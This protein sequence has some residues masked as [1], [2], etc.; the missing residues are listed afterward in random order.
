MES[1]REYPKIERAF[2]EDKKGK[3]KYNDYCL[4]CSQECK[5]SYKII[6]ISCKKEDIVHTPKEYLDKIKREK[7]DFSSV[8]KEVGIHSRTLKSMLIGNRDMSF[9]A[10]DGLDKLLFPNSKRNKK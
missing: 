1:I 5:Q 4:K 3:I 9:D 8:A 10:Y 7:L 2:F 6:S